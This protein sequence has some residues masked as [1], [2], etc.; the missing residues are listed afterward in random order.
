[1]AKLRDDSASIK[2]KV[3][4]LEKVLEMNPDNRNLLV[5]LAFYSAMDEAWPQANRW[6][7]RS[8]G[9]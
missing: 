4:V 1:M 6:Q 8:I 2:E 9:V 3:Q 7:E 5:R